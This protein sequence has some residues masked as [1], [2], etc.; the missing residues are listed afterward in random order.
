M[1]LGSHFE[2]IALD[3]WKNVGECEVRILDDGLIYDAAILQVS[4][5]FV[6]I[7]LLNLQVCH[8]ISYFIK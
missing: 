7:S 5:F 4:L 2:K 6:S 1:L 3:D 8:C